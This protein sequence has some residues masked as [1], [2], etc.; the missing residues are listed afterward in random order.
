MPEGGG[1]SAERPLVEGE[2]Y[3]M[4]GPYLVFTEGYHRR[5]GYCCG[6]GCRH[7]PW[8]ESDEARVTD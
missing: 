7:C 6:S 8:R 3:Y 4:D 5:R 2:D 1:D